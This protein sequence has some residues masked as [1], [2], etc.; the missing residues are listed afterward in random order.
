MNLSNTKASL[1]PLGTKRGSNWHVSKNLRV[2][3]T[4]GPGEVEDDYEEGEITQCPKKKRK[5]NV[6][7]ED[8]S[9]CQTEDI[10]SPNAPGPASPVPEH[11]S[12]LQTTLAL[13]AAPD[14]QHSSCRKGREKETN[15]KRRRLAHPDDLHLSWTE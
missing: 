2:P 6:S 15:A 12:L 10:I 9:V 14:V 4:G 1:H 11:P 7:V 5:L 8:D 13:S 3:E